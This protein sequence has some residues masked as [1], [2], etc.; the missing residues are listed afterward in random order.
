METKNEELITIK[1]ECLKYI[2]LSGRKV[3]VVIKGVSRS[4][5]CRNMDFYSIIPLTE[6]EQQE[7]KKKVSIVYLNYYISKLLSYPR[8][9]NNGSLKIKG[10]GMDMAFDVVYNLGRV[11]YP[12]G[13][14]KTIIGRNGD[15][16]PEQDGGYLLSYEKL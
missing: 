4:G 1:Q 12:F 15:K 16:N 9:K 13:D 11:L 6:Q 8:D 10:C 5:M 2:E 14:G 7:Q 3:I